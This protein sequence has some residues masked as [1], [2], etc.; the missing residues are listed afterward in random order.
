[1][2]ISDLHVPTLI[3]SIDRHESDMVQDLESQLAEC[4]QA[5][6]ELLELLTVARQATQESE[7]LLA[8]IREIF[9]LGQN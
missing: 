4:K 5:E 6:S 7:T 9:R 2:I 3:G 8:E 1:M